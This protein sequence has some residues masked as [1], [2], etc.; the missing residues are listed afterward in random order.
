MRKVI[1]AAVVYLE[2]F[3]RSVSLL[4]DRF[5][6]KTGAHFRTRCSNAIAA[7]ALGAGIIISAPAHAGQF[8]SAY[9]KI[10]LDMCPK[11]E[12]WELGASF[13]CE[14]YKGWPLIVAES[15]LRFYIAYSEDT[16]GQTSFGQTIPAFNTIHDTLEWRLKKGPDGGWQ[17]LA[18]ILRYYTD[19]AAADGSTK[20]GEVLVVT[21]I[22]ADDSCHIA[23]INALTVPDANLVARRIAD[24]KAA[25]FDCEN[26]EIERVGAM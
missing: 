15:D 22:R 8:D 19:G 2:S 18:T 11:R 6:R 5:S 25:S 24:E 20:Q 21:K 16:E 4:S 23:H 12:E 7:G 17:P 3:R 13:T 1:I 9:T 26:G 10:D 14:G